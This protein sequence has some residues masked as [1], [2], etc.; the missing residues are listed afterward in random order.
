[1]IIVIIERDYL[2]QNLKAIHVT[3]ITLNLCKS[4]KKKSFV[5]RKVQLTDRI[6]TAKDLAHKSH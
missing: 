2:N 6:G 1:M 3:T 4:K 5:T